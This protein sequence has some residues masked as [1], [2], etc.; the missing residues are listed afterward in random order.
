MKI[1][2][3]TKVLQ[4]IK[5]RKKKFSAAKKL[6]MN[7]ITADDELKSIRVREHINLI[8]TWLVNEGIIDSIEKSVPVNFLGSNVL[9]F[10]L[11]KNECQDVVNIFTDGEYL[12]IR[13]GGF[14]IDFGEI[15]AKCIRCERIENVDDYDWLLFSDKLLDFIYK[16][17]YNV[18][19][20]NRFEFIGVK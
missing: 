8:L 14:L 20:I 19:L 16:S 3:S 4:N 12:I 17:I 13:D 2:I 10:T 11:R 6:I 9:C 7:K 5:T 18:E 1:E 15:N